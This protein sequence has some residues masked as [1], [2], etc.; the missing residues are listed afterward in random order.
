MPPTASTRRP[1]RTAEPRAGRAASGHGPRSVSQVAHP[2]GAADPGDAGA[3]DERA[4]DRPVGEHPRRPPARRPS[5]PATPIDSVT[6]KPLHRAGGEEE[7]QPGREQRR[8]VGVDDRRPR[9]AVARVERPAAGPA[10]RRAA[11]SSRARSKTSTFASIASPIASTKPASPGRVSVAPSQT[12]SAV[13]HQ[14]VRR[15]RDRRQQPRPAGRRATMNS[16]VSAMP[17]IAGLERLASIAASPERRRRRSAARS[18]R[19][20][21]AARRP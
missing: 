9:L 7:Q 18:P 3:R 12:S 16:P 4:P 2:A 1:R 20:A 10:P 17:M 11:Y 14:G 13:G 8:D 15:Q 6:P 19:P 5:R 21:P